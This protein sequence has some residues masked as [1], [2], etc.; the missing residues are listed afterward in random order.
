[1]KCT[2]GALKCFRSGLEK[3]AKENSGK[4]GLTASKILH[5]TRE[6]KAVI[7]KLS[8]MNNEH[9]LGTISGIVPI[10]ALVTIV[11]VMPVSAKILAKEMEVITV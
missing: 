6:M 4:Y 11:N 1:V 8:S 10:T 2:N 5:L 3:M 9:L 7:K